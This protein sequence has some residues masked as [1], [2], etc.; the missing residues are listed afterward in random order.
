MK[1]GSISTKSLPASLYAINRKTLP[2]LCQNVWLL[3]TLADGKGDRMEGSV[4]K[5]FAEGKSHEHFLEVGHH[6]RKA[7]KRCRF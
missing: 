7:A 3:R 2:T 4:A 6:A 1:A 5:N